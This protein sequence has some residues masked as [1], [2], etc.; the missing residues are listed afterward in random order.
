M[1]RTV[2]SAAL[3]IVG[4]ASGPWAAQAQGLRLLAR[5]YATQSPAL[6]SVA[7]DISDDG[8]YVAL[9][10][11]WA[12][13]AAPD[14][15]WRDDV[16]VYDIACFRVERV[17]DGWG[18]VQG[19]DDSGDPSISA[20]G[21]YV[22]FTSRASNLVPGDVNAAPDVFLFDRATRVL[23]RVSR[24]REPEPT[25]MGS[26]GGRISADGRYIAFT[27]ASK[28]LLA[29]WPQPTM[30]FNTTEIYV[31]EVATGR[32]E[33]VTRNH[34]GLMPNGRS[35]MPSIS[36]D[37]SRIAFRSLATDLSEENVPQY[38]SWLHLWDR[39]SG[40]IEMVERAPDG[41]PSDSVSPESFAF[42]G[43]G[44]HVAFVSSATN[45][46]PG[47]QP[48]AYVYLRDID[49]NTVQRI[50]LPSGAPT[51]WTSDSLALSH[52]GRWV[53]FRSH[54]DSSGGWHALY[55]RDTATGQTVMLTPG[56]D[57]M[58]ESGRSIYPSISAEGDRV[59]FYSSS[60]NLAPGG[61]DS[62]YLSD[63]RLW[64]PSCTPDDGEGGGKG[65]A[66][67]RR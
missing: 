59:S 10:S 22:V 6:A 14:T 2:L 21:R 24:P 32:V 60:Y 43:D 66:A 38:R 28:A 62:I 7:S 42:S 36:A 49:R 34:K 54:A 53:V 12:L 51:N 23:T 15:N 29:V 20:D 35:F 39:G 57:G 61:R 56:R 44:T 63:Q 27:S 13:A 11:K 30:G 25:G 50:G 5:D 45:L 58:P 33:I 55:R 8:N 41:A 48:G 64:Q 17:S 26:V 67:S 40:R 4:L 46:V 65:K 31:Y 52:T 37:G 1:R 47:G 16:F 3:L 9:A 18:G 19:N